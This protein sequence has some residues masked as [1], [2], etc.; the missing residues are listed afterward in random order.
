MMET[1]VP[2]ADAETPLNDDQ[3]KALG[4]LAKRFV[5]GE[6]FATIFEVGEGYL[7]MAE[8]RAYELYQHGRYEDARTIALGVI[9]LE[10]ARYYPYLL[11]GDIE[12]KQL[13]VQQARIYLQ[14]AYDRAPDRV[15]VLAKMGEVCL[16]SGATDD[17][18]D[19]LAQ[20]VGLIDDENN[21]HRRRAQA[22]LRVCA[23]E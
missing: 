18:C 1:T 12:L 4:S 8:Q 22:L 6:S 14:A 23:E 20:V 3:R 5:D 21:P 9:A 15:P 2:D 7:E 13:S 16:R 17:G 11:I 19:F 10:P